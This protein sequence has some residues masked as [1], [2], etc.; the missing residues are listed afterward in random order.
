MLS[1]I[2][3]VVW[4]RKATPDWMASIGVAS[5]LFST[6]YI[7]FLVGYFSKLLWYMRTGIGRTWERLQPFLKLMRIYWWF[8]LLFI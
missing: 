6:I 4:G 3:Y 8:H 5:V 1:V 7:G 2:S